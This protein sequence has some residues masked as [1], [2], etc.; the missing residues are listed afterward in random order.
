MFTLLYIL[1][2]ISLATLDIKGMTFTDDRYCPN[3]TFDS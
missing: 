3:V 2:N 1:F